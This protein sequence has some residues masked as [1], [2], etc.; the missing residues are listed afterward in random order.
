MSISIDNCN[1]PIGT[2]KY[3]L[4]EIFYTPKKKKKTE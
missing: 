3:L 4:S 2:Q 1:L